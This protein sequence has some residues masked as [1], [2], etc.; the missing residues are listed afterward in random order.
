MT[1]RDSIWMPGNRDTAGTSRMQ[2]CDVDDKPIRPIAAAGAL[3]ADI[4]PV[5]KG[6]LPGLPAAD[7]SSASRF[8]RGTPPLNIS[9]TTASL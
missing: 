5:S 2:S 9:S 4:L 3:S 7:A 6:F 1:G 8:L